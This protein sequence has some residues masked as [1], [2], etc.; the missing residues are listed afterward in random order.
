[1]NILVTGGAGFIGS[2]FIRY[3]LLK[4]AAEIDC[5][6]NIDLLTYAG[7]LSNLLDIN[8]NQKYVFLHGDIGDRGLVE[9]T[10]SQYKINA[11]INFAAE[12]HVDRSI[13]SAE[14]FYQTNVLGTLRLLDCAKSYWKTLGLNQKKQFRFLH[15]STDEVY[16]SLDLN[17]RPWTEESPYKPNSPYAVSKAASD[18]I[19]H[20]YNHTYQLPVII[21]NCSNNYGPF[22]F[23][24][25]LIPLIIIN[26]LE[27]KHLPIYGDGNQIRDW[28]YVEDHVA[29]IW[30]VLK[31]GVV[32]EKYN[33]GGC[34]ERPNIDIVLRICSILDKKC[35]RQ[36]QKPYADQIKY[37]TDR[38][39][40]DRR[41]AIDSKKIQN[42]LGWYPRETF[43]TGIEKTVD[44]FL[45]NRKWTAEIT[46]HKYAR[47][48]LGVKI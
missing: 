42:E 43:D 18:H 35:P 5:L 15:I 4:S 6:V 41:Y 8:K 30:T 22:H 2:N 39:G 19:V 28:L 9:K 32:G 16:G 24:E 3:V 25:K 27:G 45:E 12:S 44:W 47:E 29:A 33:I 46:A 36:D 14:P 7:S 38:P 40:H 21:T 10:M 23:P 26:A 20:S 48:R 34:N 1:M 17:E 31:N 11:V 37:V 13:D